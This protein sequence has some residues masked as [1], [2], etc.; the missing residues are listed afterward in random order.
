[1]LRCYLS[2][3]NCTVTEPKFRRSGRA[4]ATN[5]RIL[6]GY[7]CR[8]RAAGQLSVTPNAGI[9]PRP[10]ARP[11]ERRPLAPGPPSIVIAANIP[12]FS[13]TIV[14]FSQNLA[15]HFLAVCVS[16]LDPLDQFA[17][18]TITRAKTGMPAHGGIGGNRRHPCREGLYGL[19]TCQLPINLKGNWASYARSLLTKIVHPRPSTQARACSRRNS[20]QRLADS[21]KGRS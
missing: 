7:L 10:K 20:R 18:Q 1:M 5:L 3:V 19:A 8:I 11:A 6:R 16:R 9:S 21:N 13:R 4:T 17:A 14:C 2:L 15:K 12:E